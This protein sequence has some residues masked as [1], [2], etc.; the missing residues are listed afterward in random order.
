MADVTIYGVPV[1]TYVRTARLACEEKG[2][3]YDLEP[4]AS[5]SPE[6]RELHPWGKIPAMRHGDFTFYETLAITKYIDAAFDG[7]DLQPRDLKTRAIMNQM[8]SVIT[9][10]LYPTMIPKL[11]I[12][13]LVVPSQGGT[14]DEEMIAAALPDVDT[15]LLVLSGML[16]DHL[17]LAGDTMTLADL[18]ALPILF[19]VNF[20]PEG[21]DLIGKSPRILKWM[22]TMG[23]RP[24]DKATLPPLGN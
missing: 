10:Y 13:R 4:F 6:I 1:S 17:Y 19:Y 24:S 23:S 21:R 20:T 9:S 22:E 5:Q 11:V 18:F 7:P 12:Q 3:A 2:V 15:Q 16:Q 8:I 14:P